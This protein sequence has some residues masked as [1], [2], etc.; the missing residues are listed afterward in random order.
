MKKLRWR[1]IIGLIFIVILIIAG[2]RWGYLWLT[3]ETDRGDRSAT[4][5]EGKALSLPEVPLTPSNMNEQQKQD[6]VNQLMK[7]ARE[8][9]LASGQTESQAE[10]FAQQAGRIAREAMD[11]PSTVDGDK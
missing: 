5:P 6:V 8:S 7:D 4:L 1:R 9:A 10:N 11:R 3:G 2:L